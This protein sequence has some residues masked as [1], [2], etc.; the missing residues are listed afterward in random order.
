MTNTTKQIKSV[1]EKMEKTNHIHLGKTAFPMAVSPD[2]VALGNIFY[3]GER[4][5]FK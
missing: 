4:R 5:L 1:F 3:R 2:D